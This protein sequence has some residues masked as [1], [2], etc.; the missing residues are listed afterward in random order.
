MSALYHR[1]T[2]YSWGLWHGFYGA[3]LETKMHNCA[4]SGQSKHRTCKIL[5]A[6]K[7]RSHYRSAI[8]QSLQDFDQN[9]I[10]MD[11]LSQHLNPRESASRVRFQMLQVQTPPTRSHKSDEVRS[12]QITTSFHSTI[13]GTS[14]WAARSRAA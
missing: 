6:D 9:F 8:L 5:K 14:A 11:V 13:H 1:S 10:L 3:R 7:W 2:G 12:L 4:N